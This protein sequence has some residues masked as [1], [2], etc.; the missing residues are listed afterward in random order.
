MQALNELYLYYT[1]G[2]PEQGDQITHG[3]FCQTFT[4][5][6]QITNGMQVLQIVLPK[7]CQFFSLNGSLQQ[8][9]QY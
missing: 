9:T 8:W 6:C 7:Y 5:F 2:G 3:V 4:T 1:L